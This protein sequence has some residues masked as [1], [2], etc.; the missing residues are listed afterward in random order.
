MLLPIARVA[1]A[2]FVG[3]VTYQTGRNVYET[4]QVVSPPSTSLSSLSQQPPQKP[5]PQS[6]SEL[7]KLSRPEI[8]DLYLNYCT[9]VPSDLTMVEGEWSGTLL[10]NNG[11]VSSSRRAM[12]YL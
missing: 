1:A 11:L 7:Q 2:A 5:I 6:V 4:I 9:A 3:S 8:I 12:L 10:R